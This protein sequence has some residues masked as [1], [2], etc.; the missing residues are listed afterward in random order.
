VS[1]QRGKPLALA[2]REQ[3]PR[4]KRLK[5]LLTVRHRLALDIYCRAAVR[6]RGGGS[7]VVL[8]WIG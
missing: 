7:L 6:R 3:P 4:P 5:E 1:Y 8:W 2:E